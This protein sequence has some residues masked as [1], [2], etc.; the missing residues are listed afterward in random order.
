MK[1][2]GDIQGLD[3]D[4][5][6]VDTNGRVA[7]FATAGI[8]FVP[9]F[10]LHAVEA[11]EGISQIIVSPNWGSVAVWDDYADQGLYVFDWNDSFYQK[12]RSPKCGLSHTIQVEISNASSFPRLRLNFDLKD[13][14]SNDDIG[15]T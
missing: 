2:I 6:A 11:H 12:L 14:V 8:G 1:N 9:P 15:G 10:A 13:T 5:Y 4:W 3:F 7:I